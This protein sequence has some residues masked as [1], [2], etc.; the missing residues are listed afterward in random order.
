MSVTENGSKQTKCT[1]CGEVGRLAT[2]RQDIQCCK[3]CIAEIIIEYV[4]SL[5]S[6]VDQ[7]EEESVSDDEDEIE[8]EFKGAYIHPYCGRSDCD[9]FNVG[10]KCQGPKVGECKSMFTCPKCGCDDCP[11]EPEKCPYKPAKM[12]CTPQKIVD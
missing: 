1:L 9:S 12:P 7:I 10:G 6:L 11:Y 4:D 5:E 2:F 8:D 3:E